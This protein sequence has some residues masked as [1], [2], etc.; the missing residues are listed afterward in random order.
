M[1]YVVLSIKNK[2]GMTIESPIVFPELLVHKHVS[3]KIV[4]LMQ[5]YFPEA[6][7]KPI[8]AGDLSSMSFE[9]GCD[10][11]SD[12]LGLT[13]RQEEDDRLISMCDYGSMHK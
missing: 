1:K 9:G 5:T 13:S 11:K 3:D 4:E 8:A 10:G 7:I 2:N 6:E 12:T